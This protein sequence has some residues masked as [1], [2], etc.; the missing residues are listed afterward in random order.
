MAGMAPVLVAQV[1]PAALAKSTKAESSCWDRSPAFSG[2]DDL[3]Q[4]RPEEAVSGAGGVLY[5]GVVGGLGKGEARGEHGAALGPLGHHHQGD[6]LAQ[7]S[8]GPGGQVPFAGDEGQLLVG[9]LHNVRQGDEALHPPHPLVLPA[10]P[11]GGTQ[12]GS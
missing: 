3:G 7:Q 12:L 11:Q 5:R 10:L 1:E 4:Q 9:D 6:P 8:L 2:E